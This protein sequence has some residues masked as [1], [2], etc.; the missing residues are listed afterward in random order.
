LP[1]LKWN[2]RWSKGLKSV[3]GYE[4]RQ[5]YFGD[6]WGI[7]DSKTTFFQRINPLSIA[8][9]TLAQVVETYIE[10]YVTPNSVVLEIG[11]GGGRWTKY[12]LNV[13]ETT[14]VELNPEFF[15]YLR[16]R[17][18]GSASR[19]HFYNTTGYE[20][21]GIPTE[22][23]DFLFTFGTFV[24]IEPEGIQ[25][26]MTHIKRVL[27]QG[28]IGVIHYSNKKRIRARLNPS[29]S[30][31]NPNKMESFAYQN[32]LKVIQ[33]DSKLLNHSSIVVLQKGA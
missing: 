7:P 17:F 16:D 9:E 2:R 27:K 1:T 22:S 11:S 5:K 3:L 20:L 6:Q 26:Y 23:I 28:A 13:K 21:D 10:P 8:S 12:F 25:V 14:V 19:F 29:F 18:D 33:H 24:H 15:A 4:S 30:R 31:M 32:G